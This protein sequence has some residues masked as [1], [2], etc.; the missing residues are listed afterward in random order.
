MKSQVSYKCV[1]V[2][3]IIRLGDTHT[4]HTHKPAAA[5]TVNKVKIEEK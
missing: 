2:A 4:Q 1:L 3:C 5:E